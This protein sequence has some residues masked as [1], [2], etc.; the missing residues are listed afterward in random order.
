MQSLNWYAHRLRVMS[1]GEVAWRMR[2]AVR[3]ATDRC[4]VAIGRQQDRIV[5]ELSERELN[6]IPGFHVT[7]MTV[8]AWAN[9]QADQPERQ[10]YQ[11]LR[12]NAERIM[13][14]R[15]NFL[16]RKDCSL[17]NPIDWN[18]DHKSNI[19]A[20]MRFSPSIDYRDFAVTGD[21]KFVWEPNRHHQLVVLARAYRASGN[22]DY[23][24]AVVEQLE[25]WMDACPFGIGMNWRS[26]LELAIRLINWV[27]AI[28]LIRESGQIDESFRHRLLECVYLHLWEITR[29]YSR[30]SSTNNHLIGEAAGVFIASSYFGQL[31]NATHWQQE[32]LEILSREIIR[33]TWPDGGGSEQALGY[34]VF[35]MQFFVLAGWVARRMGQDLPRDYWDRLEKMFEFIGAMIEGTDSPN[36]FGDSDD[37]YVLDLG[38]RYGDIRAMMSI[39]VAWFDRSDFKSQA[40]EFSEPAMWL[41]GQAGLTRFNA[42]QDS[43]KKRKI[44]SRVFQDSGLY[45]LQ[46]GRSE[47]PDRISV[48]FD[49]GPHGLFPLAGHGHADALSF[50][51]SAFGQKILIDPGTYDY[52]SY[53]TWRDYFRSTAA[54]NTLSVDNKDQ[55][56]M[57]GPFMW[58]NC[59]NVKCLN[60]E[61]T[62]NGG[63]VGGTHDGYARLDDP[64]IH[65]RFLE[66]NGPAGEIS[67][68]DEII[69]HKMHTLR[70]YFHLAPHCRIIRSLRNCHTIDTGAGLVEMEL[71]PRLMVELLLGRECPIGGW[72]SEG[73]HQKVPTVTMVACGS[74]LGSCELKSKIRLIGKSST[75]LT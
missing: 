61:P 16:D 26:P 24:R 68:S 58:G 13:D 62:V 74:F 67:I 33:Q 48:I 6:D 28:D 31:N 8:G 2:S 20:P 65:R 47:S 55:A 21:A 40:R 39:G 49:C 5:R 22:T 15:L 30:G 42:I 34:Q 63:K 56:M 19:K 44:E 60:W 75:R 66:L 72:F 9:L 54:H 25:S 70:L 29:K 69:A 64:V 18:R 4:W 23:A 50:T 59:P 32:S 41:L 7:D 11:K 71:D 52:F 43:G 27:W 73:Y 53:P 38:S 46:Y 3:D 10:W 36:F 1:P 35:V 14:H 17:G 37:G 12:E 45:L 57:H 51:L